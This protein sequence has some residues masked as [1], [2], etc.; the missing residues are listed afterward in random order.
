MSRLE[1]P[2]RSKVLWAT[3]D[4][5]LWTDL[6]LRLQDDGGGWHDET[7]RV[8]TA[9]DLT[10]MSAYDA[11]QLGLLMPR[12]AAAGI[13][14]TQT[15]LEIR[16]GYLRFQIV[17]MDASEYVTPCFF[18]AD[19]DTPPTGPPGKLPRNLLQPLA[20]LNELRFTMDSDPAAIAPHGLLVVEKK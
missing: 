8:D 5:K 15:G 3:G 1:V 16:S 6:D 11:K 10:T 12:D 20:L 7:F 9:T 19:P 13:A 2:V 18:L 4:R 17:G 14:H